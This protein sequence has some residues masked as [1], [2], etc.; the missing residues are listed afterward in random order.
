MHSARPVLDNIMTSYVLLP[1]I[2]KKHSYINKILLKRERATPRRTLRNCLSLKPLRQSV[3]E[4]RSA[5]TQ[6]R[7]NLFFCQ[8]KKRHLF[9]KN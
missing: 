7:A 1:Q 4:L 2:P 9:I 6:S 8:K 5:W 3:A